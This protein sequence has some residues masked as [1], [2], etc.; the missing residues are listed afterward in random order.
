MASND[1]D[2]SNLVNWIIIAGQADALSVETSEEWQDWVVQPVI[3][4]PLAPRHAR[5]ALELIGF[6]AAHGV[7]IHKLLGDILNIPKYRYLMITEED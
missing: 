7:Q 4:Y 6:F 5:A 3:K 2:R 1:N